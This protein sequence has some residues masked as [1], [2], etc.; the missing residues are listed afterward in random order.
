MEWSR[1]FL[2]RITNN[3]DAKEWEIQ[4][5]IPLMENEVKNAGR[6]EELI[7]EIQTA[8]KEKEKEKEQR[9]QDE[10]NQQQFE[11][12]EI[13]KWRQF[14]VEQRSEEIK[15]QMQGCHRD[16]KWNLVAPNKKVF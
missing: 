1:N 13:R 12:E 5:E 9:R 8:E 6:L 16:E 15:L 10:E 11:Q 3:S 2:R 14:E 4:L 7:H